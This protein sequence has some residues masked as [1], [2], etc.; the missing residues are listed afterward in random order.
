MRRPS[1]ALIVSVIALVVACAG[2]ATAAVLVTSRDIKDHTIRGRDIRTGAVTGR[3]VKGLSGRDVIRNGLDGSD[4]DEDTLDPVPNATRATTAD[5]VRGSRTTAISFRVPAG[6]AAAALYD[7]GGLKIIAA[8][9]ATGNLTLN[10]G[11]TSTATF[12]G[13]L[14]VEVT[15]PGS[16]AETTLVTDN[17][18]V[19][20]DTANLVADGADSAS[21]RL[22]FSSP[23]GDIVTI[24]YLAQSRLDVARGYQCLVAGNA[25]HTK[26]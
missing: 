19:A 7:E 9:D 24:Q 23:G 21:G 25:V 3:Q 1:P 22:T 5:A 11:A 20:A 15:H 18:F 13:L 14:R 17:S 16:P 10:A 2:S 8:C 4:I 12:G 6:T 26:P